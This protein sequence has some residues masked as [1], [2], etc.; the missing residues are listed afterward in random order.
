MKTTD[1]LWP[2]DPARQARWEQLLAWFDPRPGE[3][4]LDVGCGSGAA[5]AFV[6]G[7][8]GPSGRAVGLERFSESFAQLRAWFPDAG[9]AAPSAVCGDAQALPFA[10]NSFDAVLCVDVIEAIPNRPRALAELRRVLKPGGRILLG[11]GDYES[12]VY[13]GA[14]RDLTRRIVLAYA[15]AKFKSYPT[16]DG[17]MGRH[18][19]GLFTKAGFVDAQVRVLPLLNTEYREPLV[20]WSLAQF[21]AAFVSAVSDL[22]QVEIDRW[23]RELAAASERGSY[24]FCLNLYVCSGRKPMP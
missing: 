3:W 18:L 10:E 24:F 7:T 16:S 13:A 12:Q 9:P 19:W 8:V 11:H 17:Q 23:H 1:E 15:N 14:D 20:G 5:V 2:D 6:A 4:V 22:T 21:D